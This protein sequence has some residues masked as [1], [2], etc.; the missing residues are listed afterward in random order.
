MVP[1]T[2]SLAVIQYNLMVLM[3]QGETPADVAVCGDDVAL[4][5]AVH[6]NEDDAR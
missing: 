1:N 4:A 3:L 2:M 6:V 5:K